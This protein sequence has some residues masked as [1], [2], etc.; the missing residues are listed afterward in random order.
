[1]VPI[2]LAFHH[3]AEH[4]FTVNKKPQHEK[5]ELPNLRGI[6]ERILLGKN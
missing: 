4:Q 3:I 1:M 5:L 2:P 6:G